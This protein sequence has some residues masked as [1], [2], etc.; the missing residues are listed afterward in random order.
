M[1]SASS[2][3]DLIA[4]LDTSGVEEF[5]TLFAYEGFNPEMVHA[6][7]AKIMTSKGIS[8]QEFTDD[9]RAL[10]T[11]GAM[12]GN[13]TMRNSAKIS[14]QGRS[15]ADSLY[16]KYELKQGSLM[17]DK[18]AIILPRILS[19]FPELTTKVILKVPARDFGPKTAGL[20][21]FMKN[22]VFPSLIPK[23]MNENAK[24]TLLW[25]YTI[26][27]AEQSIVIAQEPKP[28]FAT[29]YKT[30]KQFVNIAHNSTVPPE[31]TR[32]SMFKGKLDEIVQAVSSHKD[33]KDGEIPEGKVG[34]QDMRSAINVL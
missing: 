21:K 4:S 9:M 29:A 12:K 24:H 11:L 30:Q 16:K 2:V 6:H 10:I 3:Y 28:D 15:K 17:G 5:S 18:K 19:A 14:E 22:P 8:N 27:S 26:Y 20:P 33:L 1:T 25:L 32:V 31:A 23:A 34:A 13:Y 7:F